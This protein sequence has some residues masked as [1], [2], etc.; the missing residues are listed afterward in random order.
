MEHPPRSRIRA[1]CAPVSFE[2]IEQL[3]LPG[4]VLARHGSLVKTVR[5]PPSTVRVASSVLHLTNPQFM[6]RSAV[7]NSYTLVG[8]VLVGTAV[9]FLILYT[10]VWLARKI[11]ARQSIPSKAL[12]VLLSIRTIAVRSRAHSCILR[13]RAS[14]V[15]LHADSSFSTSTLQAQPLGPLSLSLSPLVHVQMSRHSRRLLPQVGG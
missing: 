5:D 6:G 13:R 12:T 4:K 8:G 9:A 11:Y 2:G 10:L 15:K 7:S 3:F 14:S 1:Y